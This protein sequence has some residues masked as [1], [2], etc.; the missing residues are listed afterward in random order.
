MA[1]ARGRRGRDRAG[2]ARRLRLVRQLLG[3]RARRGPRGARAPVSGFGPDNL[4][5]GVF[6]VEG[7]E[8]RIGTRLGDDV[9][10]LSRLGGE[11]AAPTLNALMA[12]GRSAWE[13]T[14]ARVRDA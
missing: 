14:R 1:G 9:I 7:R 5:Y 13:A 11:L 2:T 8:P 12:A 10:D 4:P 3:L 6:S